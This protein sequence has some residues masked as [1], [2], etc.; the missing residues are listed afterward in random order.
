M[1]ESNRPASATADALDRANSTTPSGFPAATITATPGPTQTLGSPPSLLPEYGAQY[2]RSRM[3][4]HAPI[5]AVFAGLSLLTFSTHPGWSACF[6]SGS[7]VRRR[8]SIDVEALVHGLF[9]CYCVAHEEVD[10]RV[11]WPVGGCQEGEVG[12]H[13]VGVDITSVVPQPVRR[14]ALRLYP[15]PRSFATLLHSFGLFLETHP[16]C[17]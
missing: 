11:S 5:G 8:V 3:C 13:D 17:L 15:T 2:A 10:D 16:S 9:A 1:T 14:R 4:L 6:V 7:R 12:M